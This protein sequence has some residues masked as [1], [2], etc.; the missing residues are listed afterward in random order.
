[1][2]VVVDVHLLE[3][4]RSGRGSMAVVPGRVREYLEDLLASLSRDLQKAR[5]M[6]LLVE[7][8]NIL[9][10]GLGSPQAHLG[11]EI[12]GNAA[13]LIK[14]MRPAVGEYGS[15]GWI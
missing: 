4:T 12:V 6:R 1:M 11:A 3:E 7:R 2:I 10:V 13:G 14:I 15:G 8:V 9:P 5:Q